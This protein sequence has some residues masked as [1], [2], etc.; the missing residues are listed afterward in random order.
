MRVAATCSQIDGHEA[1]SGN[2]A[3]LCERAGHHYHQDFLHTQQCADAM[4]AAEICGLPRAELL[5]SIAHCEASRTSRHPADT[6]GCRLCGTSPT[7]LPPI[8][9]IDPVFVEQRASRPKL[10]ERADCSLNHI[11][12]L[13][14]ID[15][16]HPTEP[17]AT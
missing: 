15:A 5:N 9:T 6:S 10:H 11:S 1:A 3:L 7:A 12:T 14:S 4:W 8:C 16:V 17:T 13:E 2:H